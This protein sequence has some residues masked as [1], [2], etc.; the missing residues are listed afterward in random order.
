MSS[1]SPVINRSDS[2]NRDSSPSIIGNILQKFNI[3]N[4]NKEPIINRINK[5]IEEQK[6]A[7]ISDQQEMK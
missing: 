3:N 6:Q 4:W 1:H 2:R 7:L 5:E